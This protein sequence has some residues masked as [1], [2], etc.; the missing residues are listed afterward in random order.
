M[1]FTDSM[2]SVFVYV[3][4]SFLLVYLYRLFLHWFCY[5]VN[6]ELQLKAKLRNFVVKHSMLPPATKLAYLF[7]EVFICICF[8][9]LMVLYINYARKLLLCWL[10]LAS[11]YRGLRKC[12]VLRKFK[13]SVTSYKPNWGRLAV[14]LSHTPLKTRN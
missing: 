11:V 12:E 5:S 3:C 4:V 7:S 2:C 6:R 13:C 9:G 1:Y 8:T 14:L 10:V